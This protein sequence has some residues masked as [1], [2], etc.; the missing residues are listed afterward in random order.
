MLARLRCPAPRPHADHRD[1]S[2]TC[3][4]FFQH[5]IPVAVCLDIS[6]LAVEGES[7]RVPGHD[8]EVRSA[9]ALLLAPGLQSFYHHPAM[10]L[11]KSLRIGG[12]VEQA[13]PSVV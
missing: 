12:D 1:P 2:G 4:S 9:G 11:T 8:L 6:Q 13:D 5:P 10:T 3:S 7:R